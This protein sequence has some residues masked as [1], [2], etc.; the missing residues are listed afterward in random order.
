MNHMWRES[1]KTNKSYNFLILD[2]YDEIV[3][4]YYADILHILP[5]NETYIWYISISQS[6]FVIV[7]FTSNTAVGK[8]YT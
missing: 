5:L 8:G 4:T 2:K 3:M 7:S 6:N 1:C